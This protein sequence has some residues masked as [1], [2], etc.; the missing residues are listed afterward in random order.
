MLTKTAKLKNLTA[1]INNLS[2]AD[3]IRSVYGVG[4]NS[5]K[6]ERNWRQQYG[7][8]FSA[9]GDQLLKEAEETL[10]NPHCIADGLKLINETVKEEVA[11]R[12]FKGHTSYDPSDTPLHHAL[13]RRE[14]DH[15]MADP[16]KISATLSVEGFFGALGAGSP[17][18]D[19]GV[20]VFHGAQTHRIQ[21]H[22]LCDI[23]GS[24]KAKDIMKVMGDECQSRAHPLRARMPSA[25]LGSRVTIWDEI[26]DISSPWHLPNE[27]S[28]PV[29][30]VL[31]ERIEEIDEPNFVPCMDAR[32]PEWLQFLM[33]SAPTEIDAIKDSV[34][35][36]VKGR[37]NEVHQDIFVTGLENKPEYHEVYGNLGFKHIK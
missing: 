31:S 28:L 25:G 34:S 16:V 6:N 7:A 22:I 24:R 15:G 36:E 5:L 29:G 35:M 12:E 14:S 26:F 2:L 1:R 33:V 20:S 8:P 10:S 27:K 4:P 23:L 30:E 3:F 11:A 32:S 13:L 17:L 18:I 37:L 21:F 9:V 19:E